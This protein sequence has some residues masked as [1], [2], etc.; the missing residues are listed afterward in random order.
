MFACLTLS[1]SSPARLNF[2]DRTDHPRDRQ[3]VQHHC[4][5]F[6][7]ILGKAAA[8][9]LSRVSNFYRL[10]A[11]PMVAVRD[12]VLRRS[13]PYQGR[14]NQSP[15]GPTSRRPVGWTGRAFIIANPVRNVR[16]LM[17]ANLRVRSGHCMSAGGRSCRGGASRP[18]SR[19]RGSGPDDQRPR[20]RGIPQKLLRFP[21]RGVAGFSQ[22]CQRPRASHLELPCPKAAAMADAEILVAFDP[23]SKR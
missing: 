15:F 18:A 22:Y 6:A 14:V 1:T 5:P 7:P 12:T 8:S 4:R 2:H 21:R 17:R 11:T 13:A 3:S 9:R 20:R 19:R 10:H 16:S 23:S